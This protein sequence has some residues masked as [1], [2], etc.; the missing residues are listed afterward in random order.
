M[1]F[2]KS[3]L[4][5]MTISRSH[6]SFGWTWLWRALLLRRKTMV[7]IVLTT[8][9]I[10]ATGLIIPLCTQQAIDSIFSHWEKMHL[11]ILALIAVVA[12]V[13]E[14]VL[15]RWRQVLVMNLG[16]YLEKRISKY[17]F[18]Q[19]M[20]MRSDR[21]QLG[22]GNI[23]NRF[24]QTAKVRDFILFRLPQCLFD[25]G[26]ALI[27]LSVMFYYDAA[28]GIVVSV[29]AII[30]GCFL[31]APIKN[32]RKK[33]AEMLK[34]MGT[35]QDVLSETAYGIDAVK[36][37]VLES[38]RMRLWNI[39][40]DRFLFA[41]RQVL[42]LNQG[43]LVTTQLTARTISL[44]VVSIGCWQLLHH[45]LSVGQLVA[46]QMLTGRVTVPLLAGAAIYSSFRDTQAA[47]NHIA[48]FLKRPHET[49]PTRI[50]GNL[51]NLKLS[52]SWNINL[53]NLGYTYSDRD[54]PALDGITITLP[55]TGVIALIG[56]NGSGKSTLAKI[57]SGMQQDYT[58]EVWIGEQSLCEFSPRWWRKQVGTVLQDTVLFSGTIRRNLSI[59]PKISDDKIKEALEFAGAL[60]FVLALPG[61][62]DTEL[63]SSG[64]GL[65]GG[66]RQRLSI[67]RAVISE[68]RLAIFDEPTA[69]LDAKAAVALEKRLTVWGKT[70]LLILVTHHLAA[71]CQADQII[72]LDAGKIIGQ[73]TH[74][75]MVKSVPEYTSLW[76][77]YL[78]S[79]LGEK[80]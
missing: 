37:L 54:V 18:L 50:S 63:E 1:D 70:R 26:A 79:L 42:S 17:V 48:S 12:V 41:L 33:S 43:V 74:Q 51:N 6:I 60:E 4:Q 44:L 3:T 46:V 64:R 66:Q 75:A 5:N 35:R 10:Y 38:Y 71:A 27:A 8:G 78:R 14:A 22:S 45:Y 39:A 61:G 67:A 20:R 34:T 2:G 47:L 9:L 77:N 23:I 16:T 49:I 76:S 25:F 28:I 68:P 30:M 69:F 52:D 40:T 13:M 59:D 24:Q 31:Y 11:V 19:F 21:E 36:A 56:E 7:L 73:G 55:K 65:S 58:G 57:L 29:L 72:M 62:L 32:I 53:I 80:S 15:S